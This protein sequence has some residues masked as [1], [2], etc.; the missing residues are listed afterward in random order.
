MPISETHRK[1]YR[2]SGKFGIPPKSAGVENQGL[3][4]H[5]VLHSIDVV[6]VEMQSAAFETGRYAFVHEGV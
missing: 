4:L 6:V 5:R 2:C 3:I 1:I